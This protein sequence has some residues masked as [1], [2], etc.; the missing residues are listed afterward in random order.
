MVESNKNHIIMMDKNKNFVITIN[1]E[2]GSGGCKIGKII[3]ERLGVKYYDKALVHELTQEFNLTVDEIERIKAQKRNWWSEFTQGYSKR[4]AIDLRH[5]PSPKAVTTEALFLVESRLLKGWAAQE[6]CV[7]MG[8]SG[9]FIFRDTPNTFKVFVECNNMDKRIERVCK[10]KGIS[11]EEAKKA[12]EASRALFSGEGDD[13]HM[14][15]T[16]LTDEDVPADGI[17]IAD[18]MLKCGLAAS[19]GEARRLIQ[20]G[21][22]ALDGEK[23]SAV[24]LVVEKARLKEGVKIKKG[25]KVF[26]K[27]IIK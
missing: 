13:T 2:L 5:D 9:F 21:G 15:T 8:R 7:V 18:L 1:R 12:L 23:V 27:A 20:Q 24:D 26:H 4:Y 10:K 16:E 3:A 14:P 25:K 11:E 17:G 19:K 6:S 22:V